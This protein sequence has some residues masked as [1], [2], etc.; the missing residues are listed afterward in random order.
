VSHVIM[1]S[2]DAGPS[3]F[4]ELKRVGHLTIW[5]RIGDPPFTD[6]PFGYEPRIVQLQPVPTPPTVTARW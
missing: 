5:R 1:P 6:E 4:R 2:V 3:G